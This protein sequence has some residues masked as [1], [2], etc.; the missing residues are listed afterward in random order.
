[1]F[2]DI[3][4][5]MIGGAILATGGWRLGEYIA[6]TWGPELYAP[7]VFGLT[8]GGTIVGLAVTPWLA[9][10]II[11]N[12]V[13]QTHSVTTSRLLSSAVGLVVGL[14]VALLISIP[15]SRVPGWLGVALPISLSLFLAYL[16]AMIMSAPGRDMFKRIVPDQEIKGSSTLNGIVA[17]SNGYSG[18]ILLDTSAIIDGRI[19]GISAAGFLQGTVL[20]PRFVLDE[21]RHVAD[22][23]D[24]MRRNRGRRGLEI[25]NQLRQ[26]TAVHTEVLDI[27][28]KNGMEVDAKLVDLAKE[29]HASIMTTDYNLNRVAQIEGILVLNVNELANS[30]KPVLLPGE[31]LRLMIVQ[32]GKEIGQGVGFLEDGTMV[33]VESADS[34]VNQEMDVLVTRVLQT[35]AGC[36]IFAQPKRS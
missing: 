14:I 2:A 28:Y 17:S 31:E 33:V 11:R 23:S 34:Y 19:S 1:M 15:V 13:D 6:D 8:I 9:S 30:I 16:G 25:L 5:R 10:R 24:T 36:I 7:W 29:L 4:S 3:I 18:K 21:L 35:A 26:E 22:S 12:F 32:E 20:I 27:E